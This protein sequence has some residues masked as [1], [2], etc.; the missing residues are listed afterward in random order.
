[1]LLLL[2][3]VLTADVVIGIASEGILLRARGL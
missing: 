3:L 1:M 2:V